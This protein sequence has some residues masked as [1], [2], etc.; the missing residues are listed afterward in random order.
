MFKPALAILTC[1]ASCLMA[2]MTFASDTHILTA[3]PATYAIARSLTHETNIKITPAAPLKLP[4]SRLYSYLAGR[5][6]TKLIPL[7]QSANAVITLHSLWPDDPIYP[8]SRRSNIRIVPIDAAQPLDQALPGIATMPPDNNPKLYEHFNLAPMPAN[9]EQSAPWLSPTALGR[10]VD[11]V[12]RD[13][14]SLSPSDTA[15]IEENLAAIKHELLVQKAMTDQALAN[16]DSLVTLAL[17]PHFG[18]LA[19]DLGLE[20]VGTITASS[21]E[22]DDARLLLLSQWI[23]E[24]DVALV[25][26]DSHTVTP[27]MLTSIKAS[28]AQPVSLVGAALNTLTPIDWIG[29][30]VAAIEKASTQSE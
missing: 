22:W 26:V 13:L 21:R 24:E 20:L 8:H 28:G 5:G 7:A 27:A 1:I 29:Q 9:G 18:Y 15:Q 4:A 11:I 10:M 17:G 2:S 16:A 23:A 19:A 12:A 3:H 14:M 25:L 30:N 6:K